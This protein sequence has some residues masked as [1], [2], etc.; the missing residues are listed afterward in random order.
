MPTMSVINMV[1][2]E[3]ALVV[4]DTDRADER[5]GDPVEHAR[6]LDDDRRTGDCLSAPYEAVRPGASCWTSALEAGF[7]R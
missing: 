1:I 3:G 6:M 2:E 4:P 5:L 7:L